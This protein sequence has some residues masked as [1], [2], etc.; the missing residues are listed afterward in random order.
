MLSFLHGEEKNIL[1]QMFDFLRI[2]VDFN[3]FIYYT[4][5]RFMKSQPRRTF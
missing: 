3:E 2:T 1:E 5:Y 4:I